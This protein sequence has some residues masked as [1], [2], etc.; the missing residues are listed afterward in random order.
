MPTFTLWCVALRIGLAVTFVSR[1][2]TAPNYQ[3]RS[4]TNLCLYLCRTRPGL[5]YCVEHPVDLLLSFPFDQLAL[6][7]ALP[8]LSPHPF[9]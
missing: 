1:S 4:V 9:L 5:I 2:A 7:A 3:E 8:S 6:D